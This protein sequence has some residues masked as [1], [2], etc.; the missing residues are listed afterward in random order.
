MDLS[1][2]PASPSLDD[3]D[4]L[5]LGVDDV[6]DL[7]PEFYGDHEARYKFDD[8]NKDTEFTEEEALAIRQW[9]GKAFWKVNY[10]LDAGGDY[11]NLPNEVKTESS[12]PAVGQINREQWD[13]IGVNIRIFEKMFDKYK[14]VPS[15]MRVNRIAKSA[16]FWKYSGL[17]SSGVGD[18]QSQIISSLAEG[19]IATAKAGLSRINGMLSGKTT[20]SATVVA[21][22]YGNP[23]PASGDIRLSLNVKKGQKNVMAGGNVTY[24]RKDYPNVMRLDEFVMKKE[25]GPISGSSFE[26]ELI[27]PRGTKI[28][29]TGVKA[30]K[31]G[32]TDR[33]WELVIEGDVG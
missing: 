17:D 19:D 21:T 28:T 24:W 12:Y 7:Y 23:Q 31:S 29:I 26:N 10:Y 14:P 4:D 30:R 8:L 20:T 9:T 11:E 33:A 32:V 5:I 18:L 16:T 2:A 27:L 15:D 13:E 6:A 25:T 22:S 3:S 1:D